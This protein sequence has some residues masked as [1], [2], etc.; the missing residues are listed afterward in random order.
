[1]PET[2]H[3]VIAGQGY[4]GLPVARAVVRAG[5][6]VVGYDIDD[7][8]VDRIRRHRSPIDDVTDA[9]IASMFAT[10]RYTVTADPALVPDFDVAVITVPTPLREGRPDL[11]AV[12]AAAG[13]LGPKLRPGALVVLESTVAPGT[14]A[15]VFTRT[16]EA[17]SGLTTSQFQVAFSPERIDPGNERWTFESTP[18]P[19][20]AATSAATH[21]AAEFYRSICE[22]VVP[23]AGAER[24]TGR[25]FHFVDLAMEINAAQPAY[26]VDRVTALLNGRRRAVHGS[27]ILVLGVTYKADSGDM[28]ESP[29][30]EIVS[31]LAGLGADLHLCDPRAPERGLEQLATDDGVAVL[32]VDKA[33]AF[34][35]ISDLVIVLTAHQDF[36]FDDIVQQAPMVLDTRG[37]CADACNVV[38][39]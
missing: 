8:K 3:V 2:R 1:M 25:P 37:A 14:T 6:N 34:A 5:H 13:T 10:G 22:Q 28:R 16:L 4:V 12:L 35:A 7:A 36:P 21:A 11:T 27:T 23:V 38:R 20:R 29:A 9:D 19:V 30:V 31:R 15:G 18:K 26:I 39:L 17:A 32:D 24:S 33:A